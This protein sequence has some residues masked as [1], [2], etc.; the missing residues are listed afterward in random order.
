MVR[1]FRA[2]RWLVWLNQRFGRPVMFHSYLARINMYV[3]VWWLLNG[4]YVGCPL[5]VSFFQ[6]NRVYQIS[7]KF[8]RMWVLSDC[9]IPLYKAT[10]LSRSITMFE[11][12]N[13]QLW[14]LTMNILDHSIMVDYSIP[15]SP[16]I[17]PWNLIYAIAGFH[18]NPLFAMAKISQLAISSL[19]VIKLYH[20]HCKW[21]GVRE[22]LHES[23]LFNRKTFISWKPI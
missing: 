12:S 15:M 18:C 16:N 19:Q 10:K 7:I 1:C 6:M 17:D 22:M 8:W 23:P 11:E 21:I 5:S 20:S 4:E 3:D 13:H 2:S 14:I 9:F